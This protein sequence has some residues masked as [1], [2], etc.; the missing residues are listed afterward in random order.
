MPGPGADG[1]TDAGADAD[2]DAGTDADAGLLVQPPGPPGAPIEAEPRRWTW[3]P[4]EGAEC[5][6]GSPTGIGINPSTSTSKLLIVLE[7]GGPASTTRPAPS[8]PSTPSA[9]GRSSWP[10]SWP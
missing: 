2:A 9:L 4:I 5:M 1:G 8:A 6:N 7:G 10:L 3:V